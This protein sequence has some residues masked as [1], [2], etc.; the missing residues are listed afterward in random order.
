M[1]DFTSGYFTPKN[2]SYFC[3]EEGISI[4]PILNPPEVRV[5]TITSNTNNISWQILRNPDQIVSQILPG[6]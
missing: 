3:E 4:D 5:Y 6:P 1:A 2:L